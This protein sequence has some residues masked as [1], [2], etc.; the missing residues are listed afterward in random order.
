MFILVHTMEIGQDSQRKHGTN[1]WSIVSSRSQSLGVPVKIR[2]LIKKEVAFQSNL[3]WK[4]YYVI[5][6]VCVIQPGEH[7]GLP[8]VV[9]PQVE[10][11]NSLHTDSTTSMRRTPISGQ[12]VLLYMSERKFW[13]QIYQTSCFSP[14]WIDVRGNGVKSHTVQLCPLN[15]ELEGNVRLRRSCPP[16]G[17][18]K[19]QEYR[20]EDCESSE[21]RKG[22]L[23]HAWTCRS[24]C[25]TYWTRTC[26]FTF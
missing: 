10:H 21:L 12:M 19:W 22:F 20:P 15:Q 3:K 16:W 26:Y 1:S 23:L 24:C 2:G 8:D 17:N 25:C 9:K 14:E 5:W 13:I 11:A 6:I 4:L 7:G 18:R